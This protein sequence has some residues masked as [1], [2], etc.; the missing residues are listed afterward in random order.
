M[1]NSEPGSATDPKRLEAMRALS[2][3]LPQTHT[4]KPKL[5]ER[6]RGWLEGLR[7]KKPAEQL[8]QIATKA[9]VEATPV[10]GTNVG[11][12][13]EQPQEKP[14]FPLTP[15]VEVDEPKVEVEPVADL[16]QA[17]VG[18]LE[19]YLIDNMT[20]N[21]QPDQG[22]VAEIL[23][24]YQLPKKIEP[25]IYRQVSHLGS[26]PEEVGEAK[27]DLVR[28]NVPIENFDPNLLEAIRTRKRELP[29]EFTNNLRVP[30]KDFPVVGVSGT[31]TLE[32]ARA[33]YLYGTNNQESKMLIDRLPV[34]DRSTELPIYIKRNDFSEIAERARAAVPRKP[35]GFN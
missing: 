6:L 29:L 24:K 9:V 19:K 12:P 5:G 1:D 2:V 10:Q 23:E 11:T 17:I 4:E 8:E 13:P 3:E 31:N 18:T 32:I 25:V 35:F 33:A 21:G 16:E 22:K 14:E 27:S 28:I 15:P 34:D 7:G 20:I 26:K 30:D